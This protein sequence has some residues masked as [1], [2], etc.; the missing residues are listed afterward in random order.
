MKQ[1][2]T[3]LIVTLAA[4]VAILLPTGYYCLQRDYVIAA[5]IC[6]AIAVFAAGLAVR[7]WGRRNY[8]P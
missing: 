7:I 6:Y 5:S 8:Y 4:T 3:I 1:H 2:S